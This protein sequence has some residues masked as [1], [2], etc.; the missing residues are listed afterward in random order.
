[1]A[2]ARTIDD[3]IARFPPDVRRMLQQVRRTI[4][5]AAPDAEETIKYQIPTFTL[6]GTNLVSF[7]GYKNHIGFYPAPGGVEE[8]KKDL[9]PYLAAKATARFPL[10]E[11]IPVRLIDRM[12]KFRIRKT[13]DRVKARSTQRRR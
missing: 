12:V 5:K 13:A 10:D 4:R 1:M 3:Y 9:A 2:S 7:A 8:F 11:P 6:N